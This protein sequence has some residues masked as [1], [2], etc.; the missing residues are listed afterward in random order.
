MYRVS[1]YLA[2]KGWFVANVPIVLKTKLPLGLFDLP[3]GR[4]FGLTIDP[5]RLA[6]LRRVR[7]E[8]LGGA[9]MY[10]DPIRLV[11]YTMKA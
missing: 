6:D 5:A 10:V 9:T 2:S 4:V 1:V 8:H 11:R 7:Q 3:P